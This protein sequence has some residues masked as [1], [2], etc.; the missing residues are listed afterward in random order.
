MAMLYDRQGLSTCLLQPVAV[1]KHVIPI[2]ISQMCQLWD[3]ERRG[4]DEDSERHLFGFLTV[5][6]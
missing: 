6:S 4:I 3:P 1:Y 5:L 2:R